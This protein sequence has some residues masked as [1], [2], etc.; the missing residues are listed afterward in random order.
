MKQLP[1]ALPALQPH[2]NALRASSVA[3]SPRNPQFSCRDFFAACRAPGGLRDQGISNA[4]ATRLY[5]VVE[6]QCSTLDLSLPQLVD[7]HAGNAWHSVQQMIA[8]GYGPGH[9]Q[10]D[11]PRAVCGLLVQFPEHLRDRIDPV[12]EGLRMGVDP[13]GGYEDWFIRL[14]SDWYDAMRAAY[15]MSEH[16]QSPKERW[17]TRLRLCR[18]AAKEAMPELIEWF[19]SLRAEVCDGG[20]TSAWQWGDTSRDSVE[21]RG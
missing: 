7:H 2:I 4:E 6:V 19:E 10:G 16:I 15:A 5:R 20:H 8:R 9:V 12:L 18:N 3:T 14:C 1:L 21:A 17:E 13:D 11:T